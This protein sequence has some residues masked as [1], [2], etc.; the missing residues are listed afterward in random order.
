MTK[1]DAQNKINHPKILLVK[2]LQMISILSRDYKQTIFNTP[3]TNI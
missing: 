2:T 1:G 3:N